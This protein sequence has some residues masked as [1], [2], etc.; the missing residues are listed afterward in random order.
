MIYLISGAARC[1]KSTLAERVRPHINGQVVS[2]DAFTHSMQGVL[3]AKWLPDLFVN[4]VDPV[5]EMT[6]PNEMLERLR[7]R[8]K[9]MWEFYE[10]YIKAS[11]KDSDD[12]ILLDGNLWPDYIRTLD[13]PHRAVFIV[14]TSPA[15]ADR[16][17]AIRDS[18]SDNNWMKEHEYSDKKI[19]E[20][21]KFNAKRSER[22]VALCKQYDYPCFDIAGQG[23]ENAADQAFESLL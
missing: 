20:W 1:G 12:D 13:I 22:Y 21:A 5:Q 9:E 16:L 11:L 7:E 19:V 15:Q 2:G 8:D 4:V 17:I 10:A 6:D 3:K 23:M 18:D 14:D